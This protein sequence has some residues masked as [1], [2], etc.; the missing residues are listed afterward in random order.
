MADGV[1]REWDA[2]AYDR[3]ADPQTRWGQA[4][5]GR[6]G[7]SGSE[8]V[9]DAGCG[10]GRVTEQLVARLPRGRVI[11]LDR[12]DSML[13][14]ARER[15]AA[16][17]ERVRFIQAD[18]LELTRATLGPDVFVDAVFS[19]ATF[20]WITDHDRLFRNLAGVLRPGG[21]LVA[22]CGAQGNI[23]TVIRAARVAGAERVGTWLYASPQETRHRLARAGFAAIRVWSHPEP[24]RFLAG[25]P[26]VDFLE[27]VCLREHAATLPPEHRRAF[28]EQVAAVMPEP[29]IDYVRL[30]MVAIRSPAARNRGQDEPGTR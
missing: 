2:A 6:L 28:A 27:T 19:T 9:L 15:L 29:L 22:Q 26:F 8:T 7:L 23:E 30:N 3:L 1:A 13:S 5:L 20:H 21:Q 11:A 24:T 18:L 14:Q 25:A 4:V 10:T 16:A 17:G 12:S